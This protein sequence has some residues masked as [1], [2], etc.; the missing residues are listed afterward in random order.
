[1]TFTI[2]FLKWVCSSLCCAKNEP[3]SQGP[4]K[5][6]LGF[7]AT[8]RA[9]SEEASFFQVLKYETIKIG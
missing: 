1:M 4:H 3:K 2:S 8:L 6:V 5:G 9:L 7:L